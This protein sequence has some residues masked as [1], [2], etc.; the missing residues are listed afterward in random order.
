MLLQIRDFIRKHGFISKDQLLRE[1]MIAEDALEP[2]LAIWLE[3]KIIREWQEGECK[4]PCM[5]CRNTWYQYRDESM[6]D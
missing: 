6:I 2:M 4:N 1:F 3:R 5:K